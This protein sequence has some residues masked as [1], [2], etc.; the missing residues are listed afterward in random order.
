[1]N[2]HILSRH[3]TSWRKKYIIQ[4]ESSSS[5]NRIVNAVAYVKLALINEKL[6][7]IIVNREKV[8]VIN[9]KLLQQEQFTEA[10]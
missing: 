1:M 7:T 2:T 6:K 3:D 5:F 9:F 10:D 8:K 4:L